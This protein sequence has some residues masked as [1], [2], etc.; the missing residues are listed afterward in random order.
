MN[1]LSKYLYNFLKHSIPDKMQMIMAILINIPP[2]IDELEIVGKNI[3]GDA[4]MIKTIFA[5]TIEMIN[6]NELMN[7]F[8]KL[9]FIFPK[10]I[11]K[12]RKI[13]QSKNLNQPAL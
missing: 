5:T 1:S 4:K 10:K 13:L 9:N 8:I 2:K 6:V 12:E 7:I 3:T 11:P